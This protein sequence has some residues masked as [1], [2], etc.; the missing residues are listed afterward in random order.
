MLGR[1]LDTAW[2]KILEKEF[3]HATAGST[4][5]RQLALLPKNTHETL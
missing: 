2:S 4:R 1:V 5:I 3:E